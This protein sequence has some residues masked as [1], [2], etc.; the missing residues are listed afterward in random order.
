MNREMKHTPENIHELKENEIFVFGS[1]EGGI[2]GRGAAETAM[3]KFGAVF[4]KGYGIQGQ[5]FAIPTKNRWLK[6]LPISEIS[7]YVDGFFTFAIQH[8]EL[9]F[10]VTKIGCGLA[11]YSVDEMKELFIYREIPEHVVLPGEFSKT[12]KSI[13]PKE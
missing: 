6:T 7:K 4:G 5:S 9:K 3:Y 12:K 10:Y 13:K 1:N 11:G 8:P 2:H